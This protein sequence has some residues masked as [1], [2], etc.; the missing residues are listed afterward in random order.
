M[1]LILIFAMTTSLLFVQHTG[2]AESSMAD[3]A[4]K[5][6]KFVLKHIEA[7][8][9]KLHSGGI[10]RG[11]FAEIAAKALRLTE[12]DKKVYFSDVDRSNANVTHINA[13]AE[14]GLISLAETEFYPNEPISYPEA[15]KIMLTAAG[16]GT[17]AELNGGFPTGYVSV[18]KRAGLSVPSASYDGITYDDAVRIIYDAMFI[19]KYTART[20]TDDSADYEVSDTTLFGEKWDF[21]AEEGVLRSFCGGAESETAAAEGK[22]QIGNAYYENGGDLYLYDMFL[23]NVSFVY[24]KKN[25]DTANLIY[26]ISKRNDDIIIQSS[27]VLSYDRTSYELS[28]A[29][30]GGDRSLNRRINPGSRFYYNGSLYTESIEAVMNEFINGEKRGAIRLKD[31]DRDGACD[32]VIVTAYRSIAVKG[33]PAEK[34]T[35]YSMYEPDKSFVLGDYDTV[36]V[37][38]RLM[39]KAELIN[40]ITPGVLTLAE[41]KDKR[42]AQVIICDERISGTVDRVKGSGAGETEI[43]VSGKKY[44]LDKNV[45]KNETVAVGKSYSFIVDRFGYIVY[46]EVKTEDNEVYKIGLLIK[47]RVE[48]SLDNTLRIKLLSYESGNMETYA[49]SSPVRVDGISVKGADYGE[50][51]INMLGNTYNIPI[52][53]RLNEEGEICDI[54]SPTRGANEDSEHTLFKKCSGDTGEWHFVQ[55]SFSGAIRRLGARTIYNPDYTAVFMVPRADAA[56]YVMYNENYPYSANRDD[57]ANNKYLLDANGNKV[58]RCDWMYSTK[59]DIQSYASLYMDTYSYDTDNPYEG[60]CV[61]YYDVYHRTEMFYLFDSLSGQLNEKGESVTVV[62]C[63]EQGILKSFEIEDESVFDGFEAG[64]V[65]TL[66]LVGSDNKITSV[67]KIYDSLQDRFVNPKR[68]PGESISGITHTFAPEYW[69]SGTYGI[70]TNTGKITQH[71]YYDGMQLSIGTVLKVNGDIV[72]IDW[73]G[74]FSTYEERIYLGNVSK[75]MIDRSTDRNR[76]SA[77]SSADIPDYE[78]AGGAAARIVL[79]SSNLVGKSAFIYIN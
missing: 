51:A 30:N 76:I 60:V 45:E 65:F 20:F 63:Y 18:A 32:T 64:D 25:D 59:P 78:T 14:N 70:N 31:S 66:S 15:V 56:G 33:K 69:Y 72:D 4:P 55:N 13:L 44:K 27:D 52:R 2:Y 71:S 61:I 79:H 57:H 77:C 6:A 28:Y 58:E 39:K 29:P 41:S 11:G 49:V 17:Y 35:Y 1:G 10:T 67:L 73:D 43:T 16:Y 42:F 47:A 62:N 68:T 19:G 53:Y 34:D 50:K 74:D 75:L 36:S 26:A 22:V 48:E 23:D 37:Y 8:D 24:E 9:D 7:I 40:F 46:S 3:N 38:S 5:E 21:Y 12:S 54:D